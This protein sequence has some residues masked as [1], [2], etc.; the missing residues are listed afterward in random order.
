MNLCSHVQTHT[1]QKEHLAVL[2]PRNWPQGYS[3]WFCGL[4]KRHCAG[5][6]MRG[7]TKRAVSIAG[8]ESWQAESQLMRQHLPKLFTIVVLVCMGI[9]VCSCFQHS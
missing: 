6:K 4:W 2:L 8:W 1:G 5:A 3:C 7:G 9:S